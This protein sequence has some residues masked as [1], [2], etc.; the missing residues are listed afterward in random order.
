MDRMYVE[1]LGETSH[2][3]AHI[4]LAPIKVDVLYLI[5]SRN[6]CETA[7]AIAVEIETKL[8]TERI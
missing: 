7:V 5:N 4:G 2:C 3:T 8:R 1:F 6:S